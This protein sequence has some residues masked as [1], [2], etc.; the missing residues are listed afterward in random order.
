[1]S[2]IAL[3]REDE[4]LYESNVLVVV[5]EGGEDVVREVVRAKWM[6]EEEVDA[7]DMSINF[8]TCT[9]KDETLIKKFME[10]SSTTG[11]DKWM[12]LLN[13][14][15]RRLRA[16]LGDRLVSV[17]ALPREDELLYESNVLVVVR[18]GGED[19][20]R[21]VVRAKWMAEEEVDAGDMSINFLTCTP[22]DETLYFS[23][24]MEGF[25]VG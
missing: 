8:L 5:R 20:V 18:E 7:G 15:S 12:Q 21:E 6:A 1:M 13:V 17:I 11:G 14:F 25:Y 23:F 10:Y 2:V 22:K 24:R 9:P 19:V 3:P 4:L 16:S